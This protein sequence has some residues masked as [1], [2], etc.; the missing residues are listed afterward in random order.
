MYE[1]LENQTHCQVST[2]N[3][4]TSINRNISQNATR[5]KHRSAHAGIA[6]CITPGGDFFIPHK[7]RPLL[8]CEKLLLQGLPYFRLLLGNESEVQLGDLAGN[9][10]SLTVVSAC[11]LGAITCQQLRAEA[12]NEVGG[13]A[14]KENDHQERQKKE[15][16]K[17]VIMMKPIIEEVAP[18]EKEFTSTRN[19]VS[20]MEVA[21]CLSSSS[22]V[23]EILNSVAKLATDAI[24]VSVK[25]VLLFLFH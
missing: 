12:S 11:M 10:M 9:A 14:K 6:G 4:D 17:F 20:T 25:L 23:N 7:G 19:N 24:Q 13:K 21:P 8:G 3:N 5:E 15:I 2:A 18:L 1:H 16:D 22:C